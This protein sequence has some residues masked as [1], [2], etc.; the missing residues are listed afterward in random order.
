MT[1][2]ALRELLSLHHAG[3]SNKYRKNID[4]FLQQRISLLHWLG[5]KQQSWRIFD[6]EGIKTEWARG[7]VWMCRRNGICVMSGEEWRFLCMVFLL[8]LHPLTSL[9]KEPSLT[10]RYSEQRECVLIQQLKRHFQFTYHLNSPRYTFYSTNSI[11]LTLP[12]GTCHLS[13]CLLTH[14]PYSHPIISGSAEIWS[15]PFPTL[16]SLRRDC[17][18]VQI[19]V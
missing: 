14:P 4:T 10:D 18:A 19:P 11:N 1:H 2:P 6:S 16:P 7:V 3:Q 5:G 9:V 17:V 12:S 13:L 15:L 8:A